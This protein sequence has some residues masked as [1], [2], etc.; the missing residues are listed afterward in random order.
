MEKNGLKSSENSD[1]NGMY[2]SEK[3]ARVINK[4]NRNALLN[5]TILIWANLV[6][7]CMVVMILVLSSYMVYAY[8]M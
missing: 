3:Q 4:S 8:Y 7:A 5:L 1:N 6:V 2:L